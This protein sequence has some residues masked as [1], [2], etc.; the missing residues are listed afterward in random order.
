MSSYTHIFKY[1][2]LTFLNDNRE[3]LA[4]PRKRKQKSSF[5]FGI[6]FQIWKNLLSRLFF[7]QP[8]IIFVQEQYD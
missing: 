7:A 6:H 3:Y 5:L 4:S 8:N 1:E 2:V